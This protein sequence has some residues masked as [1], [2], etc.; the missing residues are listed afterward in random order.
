MTEEETLK[1]LHLGKYCVAVQYTNGTIYRD[2]SRTANTPD[3]LRSMMTINERL[4][5]GVY[6]CETTCVK[7]PIL[8]EKR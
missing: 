1:A 5:G 8:Q 4:Y 7:Y 6:C 3:E 2:L